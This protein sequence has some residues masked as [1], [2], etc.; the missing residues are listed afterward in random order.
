MQSLRI[1]RGMQLAVFDMAGTVINEGGLVY[2]TLYET[3]KDFGLDIKKEEIPQWHGSNKFEVLDHYL[4]KNLKE[5]YLDIQCNKFLSDFTELR[6]NLHSNF[7]KNLKESYFS[8]NSVKL[9]HPNVPTLFDNMRYNGTKIALNT[10]YSSDIQMQLIKMLKL[11][12]MID[13]HISSDSV[14]RG[15]PA[16]Y[17][18]KELMRRNNIYDSRRVMKVGDT[19]NDILEGKNAGC[20]NL[21]GVLSGA[22]TKASLLNVG[23]TTV[24]DN[25]NNLAE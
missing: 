25:I 9:I 20:R 8:K 11:D 5:K 16:P 2:K 13:D 14:I 7:K 18:I 24:L 4:D 3:I 23:A 19:P 15:R 1:S 12:E 22:G 21:V 10:G 17:M 6:P